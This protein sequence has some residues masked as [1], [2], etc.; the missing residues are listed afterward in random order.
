MYKKQQKTNKN[1]R[2][3]NKFK[4]MLTEKMLITNLD[5]IFRSLIGSAWIS[6]TS[7][8]SN[9]VIYCIKLMNTRK[10]VMLKEKYTA[11]ALIKNKIKFS[12]FIK[13]FRVE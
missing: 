5:I 3:L 12:P 6:D 13:K 10:R 4:K 7:N 11:P 9:S 8:S 2:V 1:N